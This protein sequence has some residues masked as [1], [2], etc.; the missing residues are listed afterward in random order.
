MDILHEHIA[1]GAFHNSDE[2]FNPPQ[3]HPNTRLAV[4]RKIMTWICDASLDSPPIMW[5]HGPAGAGKSAIAQT[6]AARNDELGNLVASFFFS[7][8]ASRCNKAKHLIPTISYQLAQNIHAT[9]NPIE[10][11]VERNPAVFSMSLETQLE[12]LVVKPILSTMHVFNNTGQTKPKLIVIDGL[13]EC[14]NVDVQERIIQIFSAALLRHS[15]S[16]ALRLLLLSRS[17]LVIRNAFSHLDHPH[18]TLVLDHSFAPDKDIGLFLHD[19][20]NDIRQRHTLRRLIPNSWPADRDIRALVCQSSGQFIYASTVMRYLQS[21]R[22]RPPERLSVVLGIRSSVQESPFMQLDAL[23]MHVLTAI[24]V[25]WISTV[26]RILSLM[27]L[28][29]QWNWRSADAMETFLGLDVGDIDLAL[30]D[31]HSIID[32][33]QSRSWPSPFDGLKFFHASL[34]DFLTDSA[35]SGQFFIDKAV[36]HAQLAQLCIKN[37]RSSGGYLACTDF[38]IVHLDLRALVCCHR[39]RP[40]CQVLCKIRATR[41]C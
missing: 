20:F 15:D 37:L 29:P 11:V 19:A 13:D 17:E 25:D 28:S 1:T 33:A 2:R 12:E 31:L 18:E 27:L 24:D 36:A 26:L 16:L 40:H 14:D 32:V 39:S 3:C 5:L 23:Y 22:H 21:I 41:S 30:A 9:R 8:T 7:R 35:R 6:I 34:P 10:H 38:A 4:Q